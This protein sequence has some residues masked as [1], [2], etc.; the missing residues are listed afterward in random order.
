[1]LTTC[2][3]CFA[4]LKASVFH[5]T[6]LSDNKH[7]ANLQTIYTSVKEQITRWITRQKKREFT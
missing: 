3:L 2:Y 1:M 5:Q 7:D 4:M 6:S